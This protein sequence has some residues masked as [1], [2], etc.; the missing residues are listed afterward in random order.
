MDSSFNSLPAPTKD[1]FIDTIDTEELVSALKEV[2]TSSKDLS[3]TLSVQE[4]QNITLCSLVSLFY[5]IK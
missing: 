4:T 1:I 2:A 5:E 3:I